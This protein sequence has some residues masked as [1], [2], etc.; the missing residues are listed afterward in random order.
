MRLAAGSQ[1]DA[2]LDVTL[3]GSCGMNGAPP[4]WRLCEIINLC[5]AIERS[6]EFDVL[7]SHGYLWGLPF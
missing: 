3:P 7:H 6:G 4:D 5:R 2:K 1:V